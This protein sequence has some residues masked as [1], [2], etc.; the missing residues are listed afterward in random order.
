MVSFLRRV[1]VSV[2]GLLVTSVLRLV[3]AVASLLLVAVA[4]SVASLAVAEQLG[5]K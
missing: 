3:L 5:C 1:T 2:L 4:V